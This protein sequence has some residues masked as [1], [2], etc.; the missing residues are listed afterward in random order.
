MGAFMLCLFSIIC[1]LDYTKLHVRIHRGNISLPCICLLRMLISCNYQM[2]HRET[3]RVQ[4][5]ENTPRTLR[6]FIAL[7]KQ[8]LEE[9]HLT[10]WQILI[11]YKWYLQMMILGTRHPSGTVPYYRKQFTGHN[12][13]GLDIKPYCERCTSNG[14]RI[15]D[16][17]KRNSHPMIFLVLI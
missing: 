9:L 7:A 16:I 4:A 8:T 11:L 12:P 14:I 10:M 13:F 3:S 15:L 5:R 17:Q 6:F 1:F 2:F